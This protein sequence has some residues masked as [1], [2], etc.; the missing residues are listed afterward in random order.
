MSLVDDSKAIVDQPSATEL[1]EQKFEIARLLH[2]GFDAS[3]IAVAMR[4]PV[5]LVKKLETDAVV[6]QHILYLTTQRV[7][8]ASRHITAFDNLIDKA[9]AA[10][11]RVLSDPE[12][13]AKDV[14]L[15]SALVFD[16]HPDAKFVPQSKKSV[17]HKHSHLHSVEPTEDPVLARAR[18]L[19][20]MPALPPAPEY[21]GHG[22]PKPAEALTLDATFTSASDSPC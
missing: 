22:L 17:D 2:V 11:D 8:A 12:T 16:R 19:R 20:S 5:S 7:L 15:H 10:E 9:L 6:Q 1:A 13:S 3:Q 18:Q 14:A 4:Y 21:A